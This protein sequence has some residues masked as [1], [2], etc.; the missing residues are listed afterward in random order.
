MMYDGLK[1]FVF[2]DL[3]NDIRS[4]M[5]HSNYRKFCIKGIECCTVGLWQLLV[6]RLSFLRFWPSGDVNVKLPNDDPELK[7]EITS[8]STILSEKI[9]ARM[10]NII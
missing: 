5:L 6:S 3:T 9:I 4:I 1:H 2:T 10:D 7:K 8:C